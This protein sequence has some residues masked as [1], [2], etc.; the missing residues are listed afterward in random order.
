MRWLHIDETTGASLVLVMIL[1]NPTCWQWDAEPAL[2]LIQT[3]VILENC[4]VIS[5]CLFCVTTH[6]MRLTQSHTSL[7]LERLETL[8]IAICLHLEA[9]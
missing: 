7:W 4:W 2:I 3:Q 8:Q 9:V 6:W 1:G 5:V